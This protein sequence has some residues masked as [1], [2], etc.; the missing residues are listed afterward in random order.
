[1]CGSCPI[2]MT[3]TGLRTNCQKIIVKCHSDIC[4][5]GTTCTD[6][7]DGFSCGACP[8]GMTG[9]GTRDGCFTVSCRHDPCFSGVSCTDATDGYLCGECP[10]GYEGTGSHCSDIDEVC[11]CNSVF[12]FISSINNE[13]HFKMM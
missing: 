13:K 10:M 5:N 2:G 4:F 8:E 11:P 12:F 1:M 6:T 7:P 3:G 9:N